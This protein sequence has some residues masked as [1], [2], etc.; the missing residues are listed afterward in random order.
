MA[1]PDRAAVLSYTSSG[2]PFQWLVDGYKDKGANDANVSVMHALV[3]WGESEGF[4]R[5]I[6]GYTEW[7]GSNATTLH[8]VLPIQH[9]FREGLWCDEYEVLD[10]GAYPERE[11]FNDPF[12]GNAPEQDWLI[13]QLTFRR[14]PY[15]SRDDATL[16][17]QFGNKEKDRYCTYSRRYVPRERRK[18]GFAFEY[19][20]ADGEWATVPD[21]AAFIPDYQVEYLITWKQV[22]IG[23]IPENAIAA[24]LITVNDVDFKLRAEQARP[25]AP[26]ELLF[27]GPQA[28][29]DAY[30]GADISFYED[31]PYV[32]AFQPGG[33]NRWLR[34]DLVAGSRDYGDIKRRKN[35][36]PPG[37]GDPP[38]PSYDF[39][40]LFTPGA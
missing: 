23:A 1:R 24:G 13:Y 31:L 30:A 6:A 3:S 35:G 37:S 19:Q 27:K 32:F 14:P 4:L 7:A 36:A 34:P 22:P 18:S 25:F 21:E 16:A 20:K 5:D 17:S 40:K 8:R 39:N 33:W 10:L 12:N 9:P 28:G 2:V 26:G 15:W 38:Y 29:I 11:H